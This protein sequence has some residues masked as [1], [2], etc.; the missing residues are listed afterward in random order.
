MPW[1]PQI[2]RSAG[3]ETESETY[4]ENLYRYSRR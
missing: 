2:V 3:I 1:M 4:I